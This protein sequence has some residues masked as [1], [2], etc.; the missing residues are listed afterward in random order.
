MKKFEEFPIQLLDHSDDMYKMSKCHAWIYTPGKSYHAYGLGEDIEA[1]I[2]SK[3]DKFLMVRRYPNGY[4]R[5]EMHNRKSNIKIHTREQKDHLYKKSRFFNFYNY[6]KSTTQP[7]L[8]LR[9]IPKKWIPE[10]DLLFVDLKD[11]K[12]EGLQKENSKLKAMLDSQ[13]EN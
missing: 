11:I 6:D 1:T 5:V 7:V 2:K 8:K 9:R 12:I 4:I 3:V 10:Y 13:K